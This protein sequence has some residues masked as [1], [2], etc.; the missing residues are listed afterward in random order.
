MQGGNRDEALYQLAERYDGDGKPVTAENYPTLLATYFGQSRVAAIEEQYPLSNYPTPIHALSAA[1]TDS[2]M[3]TN[4]RI[5]LCN[6]HLA[7]QLAA[8]HVPL[9]AFE[10]ADQ[11]APYPAPIFEAPGGRTGAAHTK[12][13]SYLFHQSELT[14]PQQQIS[15]TMIRYWTNFAATGD[16]NGTDLEVWP[17]YTPDKP[18]IMTFHADRIS[19]EADLYTRAKCK[20]W[21]QQGYGS[22]AG[23]YPTPTASGPDYK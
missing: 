7:N 14:P 9:Y 21:A 23:P 19:A 20:F 16:P 11:T 10:F 4:N 3:V 17:V 15:D 5:G 13:L 2:G 6:L 18:M 22:L 8:P 12:E 1:L